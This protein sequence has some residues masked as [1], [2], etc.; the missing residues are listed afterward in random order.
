MFGIFP[1]TGAYG[2]DYKSKDAVINDWR[3]GNDFK[4]VGGQYCSIRDFPADA[5]IEVRYEN[6]MNFVHFTSSSGE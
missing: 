3:A 4:T 6:M 2:R 1:L 5:L